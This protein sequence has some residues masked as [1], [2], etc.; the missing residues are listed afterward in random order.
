M[1]AILDRPAVTFSAAQRWAAG[2]NATGEFVGLAPI[3]WTLADLVAADVAYAQAAKE[4]GFGRFGGI[5][6]ASF[7]NP[8]GLKTD[9]GG[10]NTDP[11]AHQRFPDWTFGVRAHLDHLAL[12]AAAPG[13]PRSAT[14]DPRHFRW[15]L[16]RALT[17]ETLSGQWAGAGYGESIVADYLAGLRAAT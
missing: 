15:L 8:C 11:N 17:V 10:D 4:T 1:T 5:I 6:D 16:G 14:P 2:R 12:Y 9:R 13:Y 3:Y 7:H